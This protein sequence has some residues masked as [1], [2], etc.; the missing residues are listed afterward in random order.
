[1]KKLALLGLL[2]VGLYNTPLKSSDLFIKNVSNWTA[3]VTAF[4]TN[5]QQ[6]TTQVVAN[7]QVNLNNVSDICK[8][9]IEGAGSITPRVSYYIGL[10]TTVDIQKAK[11]L[12]EHN[13]DKNITA[14]I[15]VTPWRHSFIVKSLE[16]QN[17]EDAGAT[18]PASIDT[19]AGTKIVYGIATLSEQNTPVNKESGTSITQTAFGGNHPIALFGIFDGHATLASLCSS[20]FVDNL[21]QHPLIVTDSKQ[22]LKESIENTDTNLAHMTI[23]QDLAKRH[24]TAALIALVTKNKLHVANV[25]TA[26]AIASFNGQARPLSLD[27]DTNRPSEANRIVRI[28]G[29][30][31]QEVLV[32]RALGAYD[33]RAYGVISTPEILSL[34]LNKNVEFL[35]LASSSIFNQDKITR[36]MAVDIVKNALEAKN[37]ANGSDTTDLDRARDKAQAAAQALITAART[38]VITHNGTVIVIDFRSM[39]AQT[40]GLSST[41]NSNS[42]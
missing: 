11:K 40:A 31:T 4:Y 5:K 2:I 22:A 18:L 14:L 28:Q 25:G 21:N 33:L 26:R 42:Q 3:K 12:A 15:D 13:R 10:T 35:I 1:M 37:P 17:P 23:V 16:L 29:T 39:Q 30:Q 41:N 36:Q 6:S 19:E 7:A 27:Q 32:T 8:V 24:G 9:I 34:D 20:N 38:A